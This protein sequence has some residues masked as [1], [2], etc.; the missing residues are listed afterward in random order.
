MCIADQS[1]PEN[2][3]ILHDQTTPENIGVGREPCDL[4]SIL[5]DV[6]S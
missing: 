3:S 5:I 6:A 1:K 4:P 2:E